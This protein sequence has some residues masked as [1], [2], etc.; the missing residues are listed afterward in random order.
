MYPIE[1]KI[2]DK[3]NRDK[4]IKRQT[5]LSMVRFEIIPLKQRQRPDL[6]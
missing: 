4:E 6:L 2:I 1:I 3:I 5:F